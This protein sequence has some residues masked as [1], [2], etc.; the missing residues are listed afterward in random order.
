M[1]NSTP[2]DDRSGDDTTED[3][4]ITDDDMPT[5]AELWERRAGNDPAPPT[6]DADSATDSGDASITA[7]MERWLEYLFNSGVELSFLGSFGLLILFFTPPLLSVDGIS[8]SGLVAIASGSTWLG[9]FRGGYID[10]GTFPG[11]GNFASAPA[12]FAIYN[13]ALVGGTY[14]GAYW[15]DFQASL[16]FA[17]VFPVVITGVVIASVPRLT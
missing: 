3:S 10:I 13:V 17:I 5:E 14:A 16:L 2:R 8:F 15:W 12:R 9:L 11:Y 4:W 6:E 1:T 7:R